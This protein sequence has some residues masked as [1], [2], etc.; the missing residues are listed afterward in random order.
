LTTHEKAK[1]IAALLI[2]NKFLRKREVREMLLDADLMDEVE[3]NLQSVGLELCTNV[4]SDFVSIKVSKEQ[5]I[6]VFNDD[7]DGYKATNNG[8]HRGTLALLAII[9]AKIVLP[10]R[11]MQIERRP[12]G[13]S[14]Q[15]SL[16]PGQK[17]IPKDEDMIA[18]D[19]K[20]LFA[21]FGEKLGG[22]TMFSRYL[23]ELARAD[24]VKRKEGKIYEGPLLDTL[25]DYGTLAPRIINGALGEV[26]GISAEEEHDGAGEDRGE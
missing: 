15:A 12:P 3:Q 2:A 24:F 13:E 8:L 26:L 10:K 21:D 17:P 18:L 5:E 6:A 20:S 19:E 23:S 4:Y 11:Q 22:K 16:L 1:Q 25:I 9:W 14:G 7:K